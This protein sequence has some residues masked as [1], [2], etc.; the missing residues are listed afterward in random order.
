MGKGR[1]S[2]K[3]EG[4]VRDG[5]DRWKTNKS[6]MR[7]LKHEMEMGMGTQSVFVFVYVFPRLYIFTL[8]YPPRQ[9]L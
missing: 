7:S 5:F 4:G 9:S 8:S 3:E 6:E 2:A 1:W